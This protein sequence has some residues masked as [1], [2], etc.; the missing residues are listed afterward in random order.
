MADAVKK[1]AEAVKDKVS[2]TWPTFFNHDRSNIINI[3]I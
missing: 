2:G 1:G 3:F